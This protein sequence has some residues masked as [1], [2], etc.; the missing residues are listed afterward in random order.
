[1]GKIQDTHGFGPM[2]IEKTLQPLGPIGDRCY[3]LG[4]ADPA[5]L[6]LDFCSLGERLGIGHARKIGQ[7]LDVNFEFALLFAFLGTQAEKDEL[8]EHQTRKHHQVQASQRAGKPLIV[9]DQ[10]PKAGDPG[11]RALHHPSARQQDKAALGLRQLDH[12]QVNALCRRGGCRLISGIAL[13]HKCHLDGFARAW[14]PARP[15]PVRLPERDLARWL[16]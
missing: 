7:M 10:S 1:M 9:V 5:P 8:M 12:L 6:H 2:Q 16:A 11:E 14:L 4:L 15:A 13:I 3:L